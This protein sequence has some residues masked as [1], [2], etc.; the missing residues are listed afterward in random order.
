MSIISVFSVLRKETATTYLYDSLLHLQSFLSLLINLRILAESIH[1]TLGTESTCWHQNWTLS[2]EVCSIQQSI[3]D[4][5]GVFT[6]LNAC[7]TFCGV[8]NL[9]FTADKVTSK[10]YLFTIALCLLEGNLSFLLE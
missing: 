7:F 2:E 4:D 5:C 3:S 6:M 10:N 8:F 9:E 1:S